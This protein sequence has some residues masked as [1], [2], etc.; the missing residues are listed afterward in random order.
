MSFHD[1]CSKEEPGFGPL[2]GRTGAKL[3]IPNQ[4]RHL[5]SMKYAEKPRIHAWFFGKGRPNWVIMR[6]EPRA[7]HD[8]R[9]IC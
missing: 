4:E 8:E 6:N 3:R 2:G 5:F 1:P 7:A 9:S